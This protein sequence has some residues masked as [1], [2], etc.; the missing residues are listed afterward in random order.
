MTTPNYLDVPTLKA[1]MPTNEVSTT[2]IW[3]T[4]ATTLCTNLS[5]AWDTF[6]FRKPG[7]YAVAAPTTRYFDGVNPN[8]NDFVNSIFVDEMA[9]APTAV[10]ISTSGSQTGFVTMASSDY[11]MWPYNAAEEGKPFLRIDLD[12]I[13]GSTKKW[14][15]YPRSVSVTGLFGY[16]TSLPAD[17]LQAMLLFAVRFIRKSQQNYLD[18]G[19]FL[20]SGQ[21]LIGM[22]TDPDLTE[23]IRHYRKSRV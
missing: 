18:V 16:S 13:S 19:T 3:D 12:L 5:R 11:Y 20:D 9:Q 21:V 15:M 17:V 6:T 23:L 14:P 8:A 1:Y 4:E 10:Q 7:A 2:S 22:K